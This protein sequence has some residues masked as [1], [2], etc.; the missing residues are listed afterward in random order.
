MSG[1]EN[2]DS[3]VMMHLEPVLP[4]QDINATIDYWMNVLGFPS[5]WKW[6]DPPVH[7]GVAA[8]GIQVQ[9]SLNPQAAEKHKEYLWI[10]VKNIKILYGY[11]QRKNVEIV[12]EM[13][14]KPWGMTEYVVKE[15]NGHFL[16]FSEAV[17]ERDKKSESLPAEVRIVSRTPDTEEYRALIRSV[18]WLPSENDEVV[19]KTLSAPLYAAVAEE[20][21]TGQ[22]IGC[23]VLLGDGASFYYVK[24]VVVSPE[25]QAKHVGSALMKAIDKWLEQNGEPHAMVALITSEGLTSFYRQFGYEPSYSMQKK[26]KRKE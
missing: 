12:E 15:I 20:T 16:C 25:W 18:G 17:K 24:D 21:I 8:D 22:P 19:R 26:V 14:V 23:A 6:G 3:P 4:V 5:R 1:N 10:R 2:D 13:S 9:F 7:G 11:H